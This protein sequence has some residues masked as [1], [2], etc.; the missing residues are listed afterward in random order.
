M[1]GERLY[2][3]L[4]H[5]DDDIVLEA[6]PGRETNTE[7]TPWKT[8]IPLAAGLILVIA[9]WRTGLPF[10]MGSDT[11]ADSAQ[12]PQATA[13]QAGT[14]AAARTEAAEQR[15]VRIEEDK[16]EAGEEIE[17]DAENE[18]DVQLQDIMKWVDQ[19]PE[20][21]KMV[22]NLYVLEDFSHEEISKKMGISI[23]TSK[24]NLSR[25]R[26]WLQR[27]IKSLE[28]ENEKNIGIWQI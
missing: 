25:A 11:V 3:I 15:E 20:R 18:K 8:L 27:H 10:G 22:F 24:S 9:L 4:H 14:E 6:D 28:K 16:V 26:Q 21:Y 19:L 1:N 13:D 17:M 5:I 2:E 7:K 23:G 12:A